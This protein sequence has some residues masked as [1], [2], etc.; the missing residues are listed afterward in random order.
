MRSNGLQASSYSPVADLNPSVAEALLDELKERQIAAYCQPIDTPSMSAFDR[1]EFHVEILVR[2]YVDASAAEQVLELLSTKDPY[3]VQ[4]NDDLT[5]AQIVAGYDTPAA[6]AVAPWPVYEDIDAAATDESEAPTTL[7]PP[8]EEPGPDPADSGSTRRRPRFE[9][10]AE[11][12]R[13]VPPQPPP[14]PRLAAA[15]Q[16]GWLGLIGGP[17]VLVAAAVFSLALP[18]W[19]TLFAALGFIGGFVSLVVRMDNGEDRYDD[20]D[21]GAQV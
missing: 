5:W 7:L 13:F 14:L 11:E 4:G 20:P 2:M 3:L 21:N 16:L 1:P 6:T 9:E 12:D 8:A 15:D 10:P 19:V 18:S 17:A